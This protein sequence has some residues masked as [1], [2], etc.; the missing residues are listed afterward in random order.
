MRPKPSD[1]FAGRRATPEQHMLASDSFRATAERALENDDLPLASEACWGMAAHAL[2]ALAESHG[3]KHRTNLD[4]RDIKDWLVAKTGE[5]QINIWF[6][7]AYELHQNFYRIVMTRED[8]ES[9][10]PHAIALADAARPF[11]QP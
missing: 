11:A 6:L 9:R 1:P 5:Q 4:F 10:S 7:R 8:I 3:L 2:Q